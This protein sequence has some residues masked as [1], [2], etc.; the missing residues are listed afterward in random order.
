MGDFRSLVYSGIL[1]TAFMYL[2]IIA[3]VQLGDNYN[4]SMDDIG[5][6]GLFDEDNW[7]L[8]TAEE[9]DDVA[10]MRNAS[11]TASVTDLDKPTG[12]KAIFEDIVNIIL[13]PFNLLFTVVTVIFNVPTPILYVFAMIL[14]IEMVLVVWHVLKQGR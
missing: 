5:S 2:L 9:Y 3:T 1:F 11:V 4:K 12:S 13:L 14:M 10:T 8:G 6:G 7:I